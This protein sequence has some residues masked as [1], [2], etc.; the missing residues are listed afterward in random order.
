[1]VGSAEAAE[2]LRQ[3]GR[4]AASFA[5]PNVAKKPLPKRLLF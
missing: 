2:R 1:L 4:V 3:E 5:H